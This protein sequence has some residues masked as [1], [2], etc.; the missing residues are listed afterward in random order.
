MTKRD[1]LYIIAGYLAGSILFAP[2]SATLL[3]RRDV[4]AES[5]DGNPGTANAF[6][7][8]GFVC[9]VLTLAGDLLKGFLPVYFY[10]RQAPA[11][12]TIRLALVLAA[13]VV[14][15]VFPVFAGFSGG[16]GIAATFGC[17]LGL[18][19]QWTPVLILAAVFIFF[20]VVVRITPNYYRT[21]VTYLCAMG[22]MLLARPGAG[23]TLGF[24][25]IM[26]AVLY[27]LSKSTEE[28]QAMKVRT[29]WTH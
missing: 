3:G 6:R 25:I 4:L 22:L 27:R 15:H 18:A 20:S 21:I 28:K 5:P 19:P 10:L 14:G 13:P 8:G 9:G 1:I 26:L 23:V 17:L 12:G 29:L 16:K 7:Y 24:G 2:L 11:R